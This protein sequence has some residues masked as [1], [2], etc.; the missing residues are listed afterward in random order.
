[1]SC[2][3]LILSIL[4]V[5]VFAFAF[6]K[7]YYHKQFQQLDLS[8]ELHVSSIDLDKSIDVLLD[9]LKGSNDNIDVEINKNGIVEQAF[10]SHEYE[11]MIDV[12]V[13]SLNAQKVM[14][15]AAIVTVILFIYSY[16]KLKKEFLL[17][18]ALRYRQ[19]AFAWLVFFGILGLWILT[20]FSSFWISFHRL[21]FSNDLWLLNPY[22]DFMIQILPEP[23][24]MGLVIR[25]VT[26]FVV[27]FMG[28]FIASHVYVRN[29]MKRLKEER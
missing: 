29:Q 28:L 16:I 6:N 15:L 25:I 3:T 7:Q 27:S 4:L 9:Y 22:T 23:V 18:L 5:S 12:R 21:F 14:Y 24:F 19:A 2:H 10:Q 1:M 13:L 26:S 11:H 17:A 20:D 8:S